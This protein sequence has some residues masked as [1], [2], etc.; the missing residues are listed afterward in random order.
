MPRISELLEKLGKAK[1][2][3]TMDLTKGYWQIPL[4]HKSREYTAF[5]TPLGLFQFV[6][7]LFGLHGAAATFQRLMD[8]IL[9]PHQAYAATYIDIFRYQ[10]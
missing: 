10:T 4:E 6:K 5:A 1:Y 7:M 2:I 8:K 9:T 3:S